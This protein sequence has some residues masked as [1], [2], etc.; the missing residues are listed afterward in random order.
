MEPLTRFQEDALADLLQSVH[1]KSSLYCRAKM[2]AP[3]GFHVSTRAVA[4]FHIVTGGRC[5]LTVEG[6]DG[7][8][9]LGEGDLVI[10]PHGRAHTMTDHPESPHCLTKIF[11]SLLRAGMFL[12]RC[13][14]LFSQTL[15]W[16]IRSGAE[17]AHGVE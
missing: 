7:P 14:C 16:L 9:L 1:L 13:S 4:S 12:R 11:L 6:V 5:W 8:V 3:W 17:E 2:R 15:S 10:L